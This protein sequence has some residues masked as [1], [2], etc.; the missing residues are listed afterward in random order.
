MKEILYGSGEKEP[1]TETVALLAQELYNSGLLLALVEHLAV[2]DFEVRGPLGSS[3]PP[4]GGVSAGPGAVCVLTVCVCV[5]RVC[6]CSS[7]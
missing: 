7:G 5:N 3:G 1:H 4:P 6:V 2:V